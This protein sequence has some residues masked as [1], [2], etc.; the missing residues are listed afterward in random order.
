[1][2]RVVVM[3]VVAV[4]VS[5]LA[6]AQEVT[7]V[8]AVGYIKADQE[9]DTF[10]LKKADFEQLDGGTNVIGDVLDPTTL[11][12]GTKVYTWDA[13]AQQ[14]NTVVETVVTFGGTRW[15]PGTTVL[16]RGMSYWLS[17]PNTAPSTVE[18]TVLGEVPEDGTIDVI[19]SPGYSFVAYPYP[20]E[21]S[22]T[23]AG[24]PAASGDKV[25]YWDGGWQSETY[26]TFG[27]ARWSPGGLTFTYGQG[28]LYNSTDVSPKTWT[29]T[30]PYSLD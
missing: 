11:P 14:Y 17:I 6:Y 8:N 3:A 27:G 15:N 4:L 16:E 20:T 24:F 29:V 21:M 12:S 9:P 10:A 2:K 25:Y 22:I 13:M 1:M 19:L 18:Y 7:S 5:A 30:Q 26:V 28:F 23:N